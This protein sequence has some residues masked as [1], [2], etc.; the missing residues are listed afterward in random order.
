M[1]REH[2]TASRRGARRITRRTGRQHMFHTSTMILSGCLTCRGARA[3]L[4][5]MVKHSMS[6]QPARS[7]RSCQQLLPS[8]KPSAIANALFARAKQ[9]R[10]G[11]RPLQVSAA[12][13]VAA[14]NPWRVWACLTCAGAAGL[15][16]DP[17]V[18]ADPASSASQIAQ[19]TNLPGHCR[20][21]KTKWGKE[22][23]G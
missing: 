19:A 20:S 13:S 14:A 21:E 16:W 4:S 15:W 2:R 23:S 6:S 5:D 11:R 9:T 3:N 12:M 10:K 8:Q 7:R 1:I 17:H 18:A 22:L